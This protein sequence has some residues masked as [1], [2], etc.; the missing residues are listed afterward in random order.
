MDG[1]TG[2]HGDIAGGGHSHPN[3]VEWIILLAIKSKRKVLPLW[4]CNCK[5]WWHDQID[6]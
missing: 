5:L 2:V 1:E 3:E 6:I 4:N